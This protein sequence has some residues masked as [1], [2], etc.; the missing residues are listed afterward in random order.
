MRFNSGLVGL[1]GGTIDFSGTTMNLTISLSS[2]DNLIEYQQEID[3]LTQ[4]TTLDLVNPVTDGEK[5][6]FKLNP[7]PT[8]DITL[9]FQFYSTITNTYL[10]SFLFAGFTGKEIATGSDNLL[11]SFFILDFYDTF[12]INNQ[13]KIF[14][15]YLTKLLVPVNG[16]TYSQYSIGTSNNNQL[17]R[18]YVPLSYIESQTGSTATGYMKLSFYSAKTGNITTFFNGDNINITTPEYMFFKT[19]LDLINMTWKF[20][21]PSYP[22]I[23]A[24]EIAK[25]PLFTEKVNNTVENK[26]KVKQ[27]ADMLSDDKG[28]LDYGKTANFIKENLKK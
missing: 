6:R 3:R 22:A 14:T 24:K 27:V 16:I 2:N 10:N 20:L 23:N 9:N 4:F 15:T 12:D 25:N 7:N 5:R 21:T 18:W 11:N 28:E 1:S 17:Y 19:E 8:P 26:D 13:T